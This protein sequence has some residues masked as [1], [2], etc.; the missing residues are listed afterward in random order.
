MRFYLKHLASKREGR[1]AVRLGGAPG[2][3][4][5]GHKSMPATLITSTFFTPAAEREISFI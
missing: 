2:N 4:I 1:G 3:D 5:A